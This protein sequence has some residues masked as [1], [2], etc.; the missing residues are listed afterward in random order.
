M[1]F[2]SAF[3]RTKSEK[4][5][6]ANCFD[7]ISTDTHINHSVIPLRSADEDATWTLHF[8]SLF[9]Q[10]PFLGLSNAI[11]HHPRGGAASRRAGRRILPVV[12]DH[13]RVQPGLG[14]YRFPGN[15]IEKL[16]AGGFE[17]L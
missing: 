12:E 17:V 3:P 14:V 10:Y 1:H 13:A 11:S 7:N 8:N 9:D 6:S 4:D 15:E 16:S 5:L 2:F